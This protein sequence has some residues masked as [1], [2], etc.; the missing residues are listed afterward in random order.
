MTLK[1]CELCEELKKIKGK[2]CCHECF[3]AP[4]EEVDD[5]PLGVTDEAIEEANSIKTKIVNTADDKKKTK[6][7]KEKDAEKVKII[8]EIAE[9]ISELD[10]TDIEITNVQREITFK[11]GEKDYSLVL[12]LHRK[13]K[14]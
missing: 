9:K 4:I 3:D 12:T 11:V 2:N 10:I 6:K 7:P 1:T 5:C 8:N 13:K 14:D